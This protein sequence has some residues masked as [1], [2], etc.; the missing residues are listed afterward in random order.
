MHD[1]EDLI[2]YPLARIA[3]AATSTWLGTLL[4]VYHATALLIDYP[5]AFS[6]HPGPADAA[7]MHV[8]SYR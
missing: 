6:A 1:L 8:Q 4:A 2:P 5:S 7:G 3:T